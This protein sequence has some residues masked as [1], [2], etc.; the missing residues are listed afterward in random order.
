MKVE[1]YVGGGFLIL[2]A[3]LVLAGVSYAVIRGIVD[4]YERR[5]SRAELRTE[6]LA[7]NERACDIY[8]V[9]GGSR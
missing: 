1:E 7:G 4:G 6:C 2:M 3:G 5:D 8:A 9:E